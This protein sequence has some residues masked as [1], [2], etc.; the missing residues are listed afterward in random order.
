VLAVS[1][2]K[3]K[4]TIVPTEIGLEAKFFGERNLFRPRPF[5]LG[6]EASITEKIYL[7]NYRPLNDED[8]ENLRKAM[9]RIGLESMV[10]Y[11]TKY[12]QG[13]KSVSDK[14][15]AKV[16]SD[17]GNKIPLEKQFLANSDKR[18]HPWFSDNSNMSKNKNEPSIEELRAK[19]IKTIEDV[20]NQLRAIWLDYK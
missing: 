18:L 5:E 12:W 2:D 14:V 1:Y 15:Y 20:V 4:A 9:S 10:P 7:K 8:L 6:N 16:N 19:K 17:L 3:Q 13:S 11:N